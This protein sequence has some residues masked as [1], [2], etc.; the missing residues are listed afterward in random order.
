MRRMTR[1]FIAAMVAMTKFS[2]AVQAADLRAPVPPPVYAP[3]WTGFYIG[4]SA[5]YGWSNSEVNPSGTT[6]FCNALELGCLPN[7]FNTNV[8]TNAQVAAIPTA[9]ATRPKG[10]LLGGQIGYNYQA[11]ALVVG[12]E[13][14]LSWTDI[15]GTDTR[16]G[17]LV[18]IAT[19]PGLG[20]DTVGATATADQ[21]LKYFGTV[22]GRLGWVPVQ[23]LLAYVTG[24]LAYGQIT[25]STTVSETFPGGAFSC[26]CFSTTAALGTVSTTRTGWTV[27]GGL[28]YAFAQNWSLR[29]EYLFFNL[30][31]VS[32]AAGSMTAT[33]IL[34]GNVASIVG[35]ASRTTDFK[36]NIVRF[37][38][39][40]KFGS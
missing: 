24:G 3:S 13:T 7:D 12:V 5:G 33:D 4:G 34:F 31:S 37:G 30:G 1:L 9:L 14:D 16:L 19:F 28:E 23:P 11:G 36:G 32:Y 40:Y 10:G 39:N 21:R 2:L 35:V 17:G 22:R 18:T 20:T 29:G 27:G 8:L 38:V 15:E 25:S 6:A 26:V